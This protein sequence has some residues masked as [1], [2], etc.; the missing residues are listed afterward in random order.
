[1]QDTFFRWFS[2]QE[3]P[4]VEITQMYLVYEVITIVCVDIIHLTE[5]RQLQVV[6]VVV[7]AMSR[8]VYEVDVCLLCILFYT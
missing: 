7:L 1:M 8:G 6:T 3:E 5:L 4:L 2:F